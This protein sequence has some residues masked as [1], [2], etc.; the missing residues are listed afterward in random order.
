MAGRRADRR[1]AVGGRRGRTALR[2]AARA[3]HVYLVGFMGCGKTTLGPVLA[4][5]LGRRFVDLDAVVVERAGKSIPEI[6]REDGEP[7]FRRLESEALAGVARAAEPLVVALGGGAFM[8]DANRAAVA[9]SGVSVWLDAPLGTLA[10]RLWR[11]AGRPLARS[12]AR[13]RRLY[14]A[15]RATYAEADLRVSARGA[16]PDR[17]AREIMRCVGGSL[18]PKWAARAPRS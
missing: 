3:G 6:F 1:R 8:S 4:R 10:V 13:L 5:R 2:H 18:R 9:D 11:D 16:T 12:P 15:R 14:R 7:A 17:L